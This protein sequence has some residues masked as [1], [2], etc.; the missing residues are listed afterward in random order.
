[1]LKL[2]DLW[3]QAGGYVERHLFVH[4][5]HGT[6][7]D[8]TG[9]LIE[10]TGDFMKRMESGQVVPSNGAEHVDDDDE[11]A[12]SSVSLPLQGLF[13]GIFVGCLG[14]IILGFQISRRTYRHMNQYRAVNDVEPVGLSA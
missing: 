9:E 5:G 13:V 7:G 14:G 6:I 4:S 8:A 11:R 10:L 12:Y 2:N 1:V 3:Q